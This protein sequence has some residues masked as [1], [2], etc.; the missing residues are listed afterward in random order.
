MARGFHQPATRYYTFFAIG[1]VQ[2]DFSLQ[3][4]ALTALMLVT[5]TFVGSLTLVW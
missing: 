4:D 5:V 1:N 3:A 2:V